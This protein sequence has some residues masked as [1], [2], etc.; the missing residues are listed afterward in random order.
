MENLI[1]VPDN[2]IG[3]YV[4]TVCDHETHQVEYMQMVVFHRDRNYYTELLCEEI[5]N[6][7]KDHKAALKLAKNVQR[8]LMF[9]GINTEIQ[10]SVLDAIAS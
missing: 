1:T 2:W 9:N 10:D 4:R 8:L 3:I 7:E 6:I 5:H